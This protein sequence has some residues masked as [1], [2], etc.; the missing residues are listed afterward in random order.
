VERL[1]GVARQ[2]DFGHTEEAEREAGKAQAVMKKSNIGKP[3][4]DI[5]LDS[6]DK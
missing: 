3:L 4:H 1:C 6:N 5:A 2:G